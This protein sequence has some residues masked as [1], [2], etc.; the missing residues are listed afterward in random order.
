MGIAAVTFLY[1]LVNVA[2]LRTLGLAG[3][4]GSDQVAAAVFRQPF[5]EWG[6][7]A[8]NLLVCVSALG[9]INGMLFTGARI[10]YAVGSDHRAVAWLGKWSGRLDSP[11]RALVLQGVIS[12]ALIIGFGRYKD[13]FERLTIFTTPVYWFFAFMVGIALMV[14]RWRD[15]DRPR[16][17]KVWF[18]PWTPLLFC[19]TCAVLC[20]SGV[21]YAL[22]QPDR[23]VAWWAIGLMLAGIAIS[24]VLDRDPDDS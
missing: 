9:A 10:Y 7:K 11:A 21:T 4:A 3:T 19:L 8:M 2:F 6:A 1:V 17:H 16:P 12:V 14:L 18:Y 15:R 22:S 24:L 5:G 23:T 20:E 13:G